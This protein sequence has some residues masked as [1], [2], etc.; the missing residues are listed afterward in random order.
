MCQ[1]IIAYFEANRNPP[2]RKR[3]KSRSANGGESYEFYTPKLPTIS[4][5]AIEIGVI[6]QTL[7]NWCN[8]HSDF[9]E[10]V[11]YCKLIEKQVL[12]DWAAA[13]FIPPATFQFIAANFTDMKPAKTES[14]NVNID[15]TSAGELSDAT[16]EQL[17]QVR[18]IAEAARGTGLKITIG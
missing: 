2:A 12:V 10:S 13:G 15:V 1:E 18:E 5:W 4:R 17:K 6:E 16:D 8:L 11:K 14:L 3:I 9:L 7:Y